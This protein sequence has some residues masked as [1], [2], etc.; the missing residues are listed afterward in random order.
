M[1]AKPGTYA[2][3]FYCDRLQEIAAGRL[4]NLRM[5]P[6]YF[7]YV[8]SAFGPG[9]V[10]ARIEHH[11][12]FSKR[13]HGHLDYLRPVMQLVEIWF[14][15][16]SVRREHLWAAELATLRGSKKPFPG[17]GASDCN[18]KTHLFALGYKP[19]FMAFRRRM[20]TR[21]EGHKRIHQRVPECCN[22]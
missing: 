19:S 16:D 14:T 8:G 18:C 3:I 7:V 22:L 20:R 6:G 2:L 5:S 15:Y 13:P 21:A 10:K 1:E 11:Q 4:G 9:G 12:R 17:F